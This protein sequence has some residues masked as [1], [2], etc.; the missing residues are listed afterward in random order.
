MKMLVARLTVLRSRFGRGRELRRFDVRTDGFVPRAD[1]REKVR[2]HVIGVGGS[3]GDFRVQAR[4]RK[5][6][7]R[8]NSV[9]I[10]MDD[11]VRN[12]WMVGM[13]GEEGFEDFAAT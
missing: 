13:L 9:V 7:L 11:V 4:C 3:W 5:A 8:E 6:L 1:A 2:R 10:A 12:A